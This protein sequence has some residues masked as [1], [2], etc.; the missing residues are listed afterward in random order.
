MN[1]LIVPAA[2]LTSCLSALGLS[3][4]GEDTKSD[5]DAPKYLLR[6]ALNVGEDLHYEVTHV[7]KTK[8]RIRGA[9]EIS[10]VHTISQRHWAIKKTN[11]EEMTFD[12]VVDAVEM[13]QQQ[14]DSKE[15]RWI[16]TVAKNLQHSSNVFQ[17]KLAKRFLQSRFRLRA[18]RHVVRTI[19]AARLRGDG[20]ACSSFPRKA[21]C[22]WR[23]MVNSAGRQNPSRKWRDQSHQD[24]RALHAR[25]VKTGVATLSVRSQP[26]TPLNEESIRAQVC[27]K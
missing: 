14:G 5:N 25:K 2:I 15:I 18:K 10:Q 11:D 27:N 1:R 23:I 19:L 26:L 16:A 9:E 17:I 20:Y 3:A 24:S 7:A 6:Y 21:H 13:T 12:H 22:G 4:N 8:T